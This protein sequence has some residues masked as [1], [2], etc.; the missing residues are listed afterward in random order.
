MAD[1][2][3]IQYLVEGSDA[4]VS[5]RRQIET[6]LC[7]ST[8]VKGDWVSF[9]VLKTGADKVIFVEQAPSSASGTF[10]CG[11]AIEDAAG[12]ADAPARVR[13]V[14]RG[15]VADANVQ[16]GVAAGLALAMSST[17]GRVKNAAYIADGSGASAAPLPT[18]CGVALT[19]SV[20]NKAEV[21]V[22]KRF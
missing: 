12:T 6:F 20:D 13:V 16:T 10:V 15:Y 17:A 4:S 11:V 14:V 22:Y 5:N 1:S 9:D 7:E 21:W 3:L 18:E 19:T 2:T 8:I